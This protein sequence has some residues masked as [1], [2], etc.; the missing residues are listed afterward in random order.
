MNFGEFVTISVEQ[1]VGNAMVSKETVMNIPFALEIMM[2][3]LIAQTAQSN[4]P[5]KVKFIRTVPI[6]DRET[7][8]TKYIECYIEFQNWRD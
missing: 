2:K 6:Y 3:D 5:R 4:Q 7:D 8:T 1:Y